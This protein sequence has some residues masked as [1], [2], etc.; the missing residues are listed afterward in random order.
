M[1][2]EKSLF[3]IGFLH[4]GF[5][6]CSNEYMGFMV[7]RLTLDGLFLMFQMLNSE[8]LRLAVC[9]YTWIRK[10]SN[11]Y[12]PIEV[13]RIILMSMMQQK[14][15]ANFCPASARTTLSPILFQITLATISCAL[16]SLASFLMLQSVEKV[17]RLKDL[18]LQSGIFDEGA[19]LRL[20]WSDFHVFDLARVGCVVA[21]FP[22][23]GGGSNITLRTFFFP[24]VPVL[25]EGTANIPLVYEARQ[26]RPVCTMFLGVMHSLPKTFEKSAWNFH[27][28]FEHAVGHR[29]R[30]QRCTRP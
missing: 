25:A 14:T 30:Y 17:L 20:P 23:D 13:N 18:K 21:G 10:R 29:V 19:V 11:M 9:I 22:P 27:G 28:C 4:V 3:D 5:V 12:I 7:L 8:L 24:N 16:T 26:Q 2:S 15:V 1:I 6:S